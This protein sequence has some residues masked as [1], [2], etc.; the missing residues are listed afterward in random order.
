MTE[1]TRERS[2]KAS[3]GAGSVIRPN[4]S[5]PRDVLPPAAVRSFEGR[6]HQE[7]EQE[8][9]K[10]AHAAQVRALQQE[11][12]RQQE[13]LMQALAERYRLLQSVSFPCSMSSSRPGDTAT[14]SLLSQPGCSLLSERCR[15]LLAAA[16]KGF[17]TRR[18]LRTE[19]VAQLGRTVRDTHQFLQALQ[20]PSPSSRQDVLLQERVT[21]QLRA[22]RYEVH[23]I[24]FSLS[25]GR[26]CS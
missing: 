6:G 22:T 8:Q 5:S 16:V 21:L 23:D 1:E 19:R 3:R 14:F 11:H 12:R 4:I 10:Q 13:E 20:Q 25:A 2:A 24:F 15:P 7:A 18:M 26:G 9:L 17:L